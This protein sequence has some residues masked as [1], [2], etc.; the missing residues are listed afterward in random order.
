MVRTVPAMTPSSAGELQAA[1]HAV[2]DNLAATVANA[3]RHAAPVIRPTRRSRARWFLAALWLVLA[4]ADTITTA[5][6][7]RSPDLMEGNPAAAAVFAAVGFWPAQ[8]LM[9]TFEL[10]PAA[11]LIAPLS[12]LSR[13]ARWAVRGTVLVLLVGKALV[14]A[15]NCLHLAG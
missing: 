7:L 5:V 13:P 3:P 15:S 6:A 2:R 12:R 9:V 1:L 11:L 4:A 8:A 10:I 14:V